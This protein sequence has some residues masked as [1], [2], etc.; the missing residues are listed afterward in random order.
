MILAIDCELIRL[1]GTAAI[2]REQ[3]ELTLSLSRL[4]T[5]EITVAICITNIAFPRSLR[6]FY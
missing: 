4:V 3:H 5:S 1:V 2:D 6:G